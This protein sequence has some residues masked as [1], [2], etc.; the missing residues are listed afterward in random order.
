MKY[1]YGC[2]QEDHSIKRAGPGLVHV[3]VKLVVRV[4]WQEVIET[5]QGVEIRGLCG[6]SFDS[7]GL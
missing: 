7:S 1:P 6:S 5:E 4:L 3:A 2:P